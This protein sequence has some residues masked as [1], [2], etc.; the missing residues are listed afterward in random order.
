MLLHL[1]ENAESSLLIGLDFYQKYLDEDLTHTEIEYYGYLKYAII[2]IHNSVELYVKKL[3]SQ[4]NDLLIYDA[5]TIDNPDI[6]K[7]IG[8][9]Y[10]GKKKMHLDYFMASFGEKYTTLSFSKCLMRFKALFD[11]SDNVID[12]LIKLNNYRNVLTHFGMEGVYEQDKMIFTLNETLSIVNQKLFPLINNGREIIEPEL[13]AKIINFLNENKQG[14][15]EVWE[16][17]NEYV[18]EHYNNKIEEMLRQE[19]EFEEIVGI[20]NNFE[21]DGE[22]LVLNGKNKNLELLIKDLPE[23]NISAMIFHN[24][25][26]AIIDYD[27]YDEENVNIYY[28]T[29]DKTYDDIKALK[30]CVWR[31]SNNTQYKRIPL[32][33]KSF[34]NKVLSN[35]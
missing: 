2:G 31:D 10:K 14:F 9:T 12:V 11:I 17:S 35:C 32:N 5:E 21:Y 25:V 13:S 8:K 23:K 34:I 1:S 7:Y 4:V 24:K 29:K 28:P 18:I 3:L 20:K 26:L 22:K 27:L 30:S 6:L 15:Y 16:A 33:T 19:K